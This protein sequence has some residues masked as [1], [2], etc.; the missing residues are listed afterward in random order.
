MRKFG[1]NN[2]NYFEFQIEGSDEVYKIP[3]AANMPF[4]ILNNMNNASEEDRFTMQVEMLRKYMGDAVDDL[5]A[6]TLSDILEAWGEE[7][8]KAGASLG[9][10]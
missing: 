7:S 5:T 1:Q 4:S 3:L 10:S 8:M 6:G 2:V 9:E